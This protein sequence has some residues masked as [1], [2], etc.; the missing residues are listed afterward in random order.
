MKRAMPAK[1]AKKSED[2]AKVNQSPKND[3]W[4]MS[5]KDFKDNG[6]LIN[7]D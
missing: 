2:K 7:G 3:N 1:K 4:K 6:C 5:V